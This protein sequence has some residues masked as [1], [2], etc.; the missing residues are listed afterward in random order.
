MPSLLVGHHRPGFYLRVITEGVIT[1]G[2]VIRKTADGPHRV[3]VAEIDALLYLPNRDVERM[4]VALDIPALSPGWQ[5]SFRAL[6][7]A[8]GQTGASAGGPAIGTEPAWPGFQP[9][10]VVEVTPESRTVTS[11]RLAHPT[12]AALPPVRA[13][14]YVT[15]RIPTAGRPVVRSYSLSGSPRADTYRI[16]V[17]REEG[18]LASGWLHEHVHA[19][20][21]LDVAAPRGEFILAPGDG[22]VLL[23]SAG[24]GATPVLG[25]LHELAAARRRRTVWWFHAARGPADHAFAAEAADLVARLPHARLHVR[26]S[27]GPAGGRP[28]QVGIPGGAVSFGH[29]D[30]EAFTLAGV[31]ADADAYLCGPES[32][33]RDM[34]AALVAVAVEAGR[35]HIE[36]FGT[37]SP[38]NPG[39]VDPRRVPPHPPA[40]APGVGPTVTFARGGLSVPFDPRYG[41]LLALAEA[42]DI[43]TR[44]SCRTGV[45]HTCSTPLLTGKVVYRPDPLEPATPGQ[46]LICCAAPVTDLVLDL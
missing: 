21:T 37:R 24:I 12:G 16:S 38:I 42:C 20:D 41:S 22:P 33:M 30:A 7:A 18:G 4:R 45:C 1:A 19:G 23:V 44:W 11:I 35:I 8:A 46:A 6:L 25:M 29:L 17:K 34:A 43:P 3:S 5:G 13:G 40:G 31:P 32:F 26:Y 27:G 2:D 28:D 36:L 39:I 10:L 9:L 15:M 14:Q